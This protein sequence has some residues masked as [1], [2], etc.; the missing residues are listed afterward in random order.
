MA[1][2]VQGERGDRL[3]GVLPRPPVQ[4][5]DV[6]PALV[7]RGPHAGVGLGVVGHPWQG[8]PVRPAEHGAEV[9]EFPAGL[10]LDEAE[11]IGAGRRQ[12][13][14]D[15]VLAEPVEVPKQ[16][17]AGALEVGVQ[18]CL[19]VKIGHSRLYASYV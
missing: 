5:D 11:Q 6:G 17:L 16:R 8:L 19:G 15:V 1:D 2:S 4:G 12:R 18:I 9:L 7:R 10:M 3:V 13:P 14:S